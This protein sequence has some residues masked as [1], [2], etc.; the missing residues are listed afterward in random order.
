MN[1]QRLLF[2]KT[3]KENE[4]IVIKG[5]YSVE[6]E[7]FVQVIIKQSDILNVVQFF[8]N[9]DHD[10]EVD[11]K[12]DPNE[13]VL[14]RTLTKYSDSDYQVIIRARKYNYSFENCEFRVCSYW[15]NENI[16]SH[17]IDIPYKDY[18]DLR[19]QLDALIAEIEKVL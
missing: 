19:K 16:R 12:E 17:S 6:P 13:N 14:N 15:E 9:L 5:Y 8:K 2:F 11:I 18:E 7:Y 10:P 4:N 3:K 1:G